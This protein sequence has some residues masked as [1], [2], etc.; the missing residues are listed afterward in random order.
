[1]LL[2]PGDLVI[3]KLKCGIKKLL[4]W[5]DR[6]GVGPH[7]VVAEIEKGAIMTVLRIESYGISPERINKEWKQGACFM[8]TD[9]GQLGWVGAGW[10]KK[11]PSTS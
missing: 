6:N 11:L 4:L 1:M 7:E 8:L 2:A 3:P 10:L 5:S 9:K